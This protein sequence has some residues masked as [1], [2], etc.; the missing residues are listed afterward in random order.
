MGT[1]F[2]PQ[3][4]YF[5]RMS[6]R[7][8]VLITMINDIFDVY[9]KLDELEL[10]TDTVERLVI[11]YFVLHASSSYVKST[12]DTLNVDYIKNSNLYYWE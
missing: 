12:F 8:N 11:M 5:R 9:G 2:E 10:F 3:F 6:T 7:V 1:R 4:G